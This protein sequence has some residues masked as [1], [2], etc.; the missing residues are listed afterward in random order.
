MKKIS[1]YIVFATVF[2]CLSVLIFAMGQTSVN[3]IV[4][5]AVRFGD[6]SDSGFL[7]FSNQTEPAYAG[8]TTMNNFASSWTT[9][10]SLDMYNKNEYWGYG[11]ATTSAYDT[12]YLYFGGDMSTAISNGRIYARITVNRSSCKADS[13]SWSISGG[14]SASGTNANVASFSAGGSTTL[15]TG[16][17]TLYVYVYDSQS[18]TW[19][20]STI[21]AEAYY[22]SSSIVIECWYKSNTVTFSS[23]N[24]T[25]GSV[26]TS[27]VTISSFSGIASSTASANSNYYFAGWDS[28]NT[29]S[30]LQYTSS[31][32]FT[33]GDSTS[34]KAYFG[35]IDIP[36][37][38]YT[39]NGSA[40][41]PTAT[42]VSGYSFTYLYEGTAY[43]GTTY[44]ASTAPTKAGSYTVTAYMKNNTTNQQVGQSSAKSFTINKATPVI[45]P[46]ART[47][48]YGQSLSTVSPNGTAVNNV[49]SSL[50]VAGQFRWRDSARIPALNTNAYEAYFLAS[51]T[52]N[53]VSNEINYNVSVTAIRNYTIAAID[54][55]SSTGVES[56]VES[57]N[58]V[59]FNDALTIPVN[60]NH[61]AQVSVIASPYTAGNYV[62]AGWKKN[63]VYQTLSTTYTYTMAGEGANEYGA[64]LIAIFL[65]IDVSGL[66]YL[67]DNVFRYQRPFSGDVEAF[68]F[69][70]SLDL[71]SYNLQNTGLS[72]IGGGGFPVAIGQKTATFLIKNTALA[73]DNIVLNGTINFIITEGVVSY[74][75]F[76]RSIGYNQVT[77]WGETIYY[78]LTVPSAMQN[79]IQYYM[80]QI[81]GE[82]DWHIVNNVYDGETEPLPIAPQINQPGCPVLFKAGAAEAGESRVV[83]YL[84]KAISNEYGT[85]VNAPPGHKSVA[86]S[87]SLASCK[88]DKV[89][90]MLS[91]QMMK[92]GIPYDGSW[93]NTDV[94]FVFTV[95]YGASGAQI[96][97][98]NSTSSPFADTLCGP[99]LNYGDNTAITSAATYTWTISAE[100]MSRNFYFRLITGTNKLADK[101]D[102]YVLKIDKTAPVIGEA[103]LEKP[104]NSNGWLGET[105]YAVFTVTDTQN[106]SGVSAI[107]VAPSVTFSVNS[108][109]GIQPLN[110]TCRLLIADYRIY[111]VTATDTAGNQSTREFRFQVDTTVPSLSLEAGSYTADVWTCGSAVFNILASMGASGAKFYYKLGSQNYALI[112][113]DSFIK[114]QGAASQPFQNVRQNLV[115][116][117]EMNMTL[118]LKVVTASGLQTELP[119]G[120][121]KIDHTLPVIESITNMQIY[122]GSTWLSTPILVDFFARDDASGINVSAVAVNNGGT[123]NPNGTTQNGYPKFTFQIDKCTQYTAEVYDV[124][125]NRQQYVFWANVDLGI[126]E[127][128]FEAF[129]GSTSQP[130]AF[131]H[132]INY[133]TYGENAY[134]RFVFDMT[135]S[136]SGAKIQYMDSSN[137]WKDLTEMLHEVGNENALIQHVVTSVDIR[138][139]QNSPFRIRLITGSGKTT[140]IED[141]GTIMIDST[142]PYFSS[143]PVF[144]NA[145]NINEVISDFQTQWTNKVVKAR[146][147]PADITSGIQNVSVMR[148]AVEDT[149]FQYGAPVAC[150]KEAATIYYS[151][152]MDSYANYRLSLT[153]GSGNSSSYPLITAKIDITNGFLLTVEANKNGMPYVSGGWMQNADDIVDFSFSVV[154]DPESGYTGFGASGGWVEFSVDG[155]ATWQTEL[156]LPEGTQYL[157]PVPGNPLAATMTVSIQQ[158]KTYIFRARTGAGNATAP[159][160]PYTI[161]KDTVTPAISYTVAANGIAYGGTWTAY[162][163]VFTFTVSV[164]ASNG[165]IQKLVSSSPITDPTSS[166]EDQWADAVAVTQGVGVQ[167]TYRINTTT[168]SLYHYF[169]IKAGTDNKSTAPSGTLVRVDKST[170]NP[171]F[172]LF[173]GDTMYAGGWTGTSLQARLVVTENIP[174]GYSVYYGKAEVGGSVFTYEQTALVAQEGVYKVDLTSSEEKD[175]RFRIVTNAGSTFYS[176][177]QT[178]RIDKIIPTFNIL[179]NGS[180][181]RSYNESNPNAAWYLEDVV[182]LYQ[183]LILG[184]SGYTNQYSV[185]TNGTW[186]DWT[187]QGILNDEIRFRDESVSGGTIRELRFRVLS[188][189]GLYEEKEYTLRIDDNIYHVNLKQLVG[190]TEGLS[191]AT[192]VSGIRDVQ[193][194]ESVTV[195]FTNAQGYRLKMISVKN[196]YYAISGTEY[197]QSLGV[198]DYDYSRMYSGEYIFDYRQIVLSGDEEIYITAGGS[199]I[200]INLYFIKDI[201]LLYSNLVQTLQNNVVSDI[202]ITVDEYG[203]YSTYSA[204]TL[205]FEVTYNGYSQIPQEIGLY[206]IHVVSDNEDFSIVNP[207]YQIINGEYTELRLVVRY[208]AG[209]GNIYDPYVLTTYNDL[210]YISFYM[211]GSEEYDYLGENRLG[212]TFV[213]QNDIEL[214][215]DFAPLCADENNKFQGYFY[216]NNHRIFYNGTYITQEDFGLFRYTANAFFINLGIK[217]NVLSGASSGRT[218]RIGLF[219]AEAAGTS[220]ISCYAYGNM[221]LS[222]PGAYE[223]GGLIGKASAGLIVNCFSDVHMDVQNASG[224]FG[225]IVGGFYSNGDNVMAVAGCYS[226]GNIYVDNFVNGLMMGSQYY[227]GSYIGWLQAP[228]ETELLA[229]LEASLNISAI[230][231][232][233]HQ[234][235]TVKGRTGG[236]SYTESLDIGIGNEGSIAYEYSVVRPYSFFLQSEAY[237]GSPDIG[238]N[239]SLFVLSL[240]R[241]RIVE[242]GFGDAR[243][244]AESPFNVNT[245]AKLLAVNIFPWAHFEQSADLVFPAGS[246]SLSSK[247]PFAGIYDG[248]N[249]TLVCSDLT[250]NSNYGGLFAL[251]YGGVIRNLKTIGISIVFNA[252]SDV[253]IGGIV[254]YAV[255]A[256]IRN[257]VAS[258]TI[259]IEAARNTVYAGGIAGAFSSSS[260]SDC[261]SMI[262]I[263]V[264]NASNAYVGGIMAQAQGLTNISNVV[265]L[266]RIAV[267]FSKNGYVGA[268]IGYTYDQGV[269]GE[270]LYNIEG[271]TYV[272]GRLY[273]QSIGSNLGTVQEIYNRS[274]NDTVSAANGVMVG[275]KSILEL[276]SNLYPFE[277]GTGT[278]NDPFRIANYTQLLKIGNYM[279]ANFKLVADIVIGD[280]D[281]DTN[282]N[283][284]ADGS[285]PGN[286]PHPDGIVDVYDAYD[287]SFTS[288]GKGVA[289]TGSL[290][291]AKPGGGEY[292]ISGLTAPLF[293]INNGTINN[294]TLN[295]TYRQYIHQADVPIGIQGYKV[296]ASGEDVVFGGLAKYNYAN[297]KINSVTVAGNVYIAAAGKAK[298]KA[299]GIIVVMYGGTIRGS[300][301]AVDMTLSSLLIDAGGI[302]GTLEG[303]SSIQNSAS[304]PYTLNYNY[305]VATIRASGGSVKAGL[306]VGAVRYQYVNLEVTQADTSAHVY[307]NG[308]DK[309]SAHLI[310]YSIV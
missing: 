227:V 155:G 230:N 95:T 224:N 215:N 80:Y 210:V 88:L 174:S 173:S 283:G 301:N 46:I 12:E 242:A 40:Q 38:T 216:G 104:Y 253:S 41:G 207:D 117:S 202:G 53:Y 123:I 108:G 177:P 77:G 36:V 156:A 143:T 99:V 198:P 102:P 67:G 221:T 262:N 304:G 295:V 19:Y 259:S 54:F 21:K 20:P 2:I 126:P 267:N 128:T 118:T 47:L 26:S 24:T 309:G 192:D 79:T 225:G 32:G 120:T 270:K 170:I 294:L 17:I 250:T 178:Y 168:D 44:S 231:N 260:M 305:T 92:G 278:M 74:E 181:P 112:G 303:N 182:V 184:I 256:E 285:E 129:V 111:T 167:Y 22:Y 68:S 306:I 190:S 71:N 185:K 272:N 266:S 186:S 288:I 284:I 235:V 39:Y 141:L 91:V 73:T 269:S 290:S 130:Y 101:T 187:S 243:G 291:G 300:L 60:S 135:I 183:S 56:L 273:N 248:K 275:N 188:G 82:S 62:F 228:F 136:P 252:A 31:Q 219:A 197:A 11:T 154:F 296:D 293:E 144:T 27:S 238:V 234:S 55:C 254:G 49:N 16:N 191:F 307:I 147:V 208:Y 84:F 149:L 93:V 30:Y 43:D 13:S 203:F 302:A 286:A 51:D 10:L 201:V 90:P 289:F 299:G 172:G 9:G 85:T 193:R 211:N 115:L 89:A 166:P 64:Q 245:V 310:G 169:R 100:Q 298:I 35:V 160:D 176:A 180:E 297:G 142:L 146:F 276:I 163:V 263:T 218:N 133:S 152:L 81:E 212:S 37:G 194:G 280:I 158:V 72:Y 179:F 274:Y 153:D 236:R 127:M 106:F 249:H 18:G 78:R 244:T 70:Y 214:P 308:T 124:A 162:D 58:T 103:Y 96:L 199:D 97:Y 138:N 150:E 237:L 98:R 1:K 132:W 195:S 75:V 14:L 137:I 281:G 204:E 48:Y 246:V 157:I 239:N 87:A 232:Y 265:S 213:L 57:R 4:E 268:T 113:S 240:S 165:K 287:Y 223:V 175:I 264:N 247:I 200:E 139:D 121:V 86:T 122:Q 33:L 119:F 3:S 171:T 34:H 23:E 159:S 222:G 15:L 61:S 110:N 140:G 105:S 164:G 257:I 271:S 261:V 255:N 66:E 116:D 42:S 292:Y 148:Y 8:S 109:V 277:G 25:R 196:A 205:E 63:G 114:E 29:G 145:A 282:N 65:K 125:G 279:Y 131:D 258:G 220:L 52:N 229:Q 241:L 94:T 226:V 7:Q 151:F 5:K 134:V 69:R 233:L 161:R 209:S 45:T 189:A 28:V 217:F 59:A 50:S 83:K 206:D 107:Q 6:D 251:I 76:N